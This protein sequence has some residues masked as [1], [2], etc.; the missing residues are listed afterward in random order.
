MVRARCHRGP[1]R[2]GQ[3]VLAEVVHA[4]RVGTYISLGARSGIDRPPAF[5][6]CSSDQRGSADLAPTR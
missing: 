6:A 3:Y 1:G 4:A 5:A 2:L